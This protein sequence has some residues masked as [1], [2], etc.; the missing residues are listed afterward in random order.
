MPEQPFVEAR[1]LEQ[2]ETVYRRLNHVIIV[3]AETIR[4]EKGTP[5]GS[6][7]QVGE[8]AFH[9]PLLSGTAQYLIEL[10]MRELK[11][12]ARFDKPGDLQRMAS[13]CI[14]ATD[15]DEAYLVGQMGVRALL[16]GESDKM[17]TLVRHMTPNYS[18]TTG[19]VELAKIANMQRLMPDEYLD[20]SK[21]MV[22]QAFYDYALPL[23]GEPLPHYPE[24]EIIGVKP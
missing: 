10:V 3:A 9:H 24:L 15:R 2:V 23:I 21:T 13:F 12:R 19:L 11:V 5:L 4:D 18:C 20:K 17:V 16:D 14:S 8:D 22:T 1:F 6:V 7:G